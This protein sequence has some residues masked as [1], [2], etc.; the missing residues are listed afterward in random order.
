MAQCG[1]VGG[2][3]GELHETLTACARYYREE[4][5]EAIDVWPLVVQM[6]RALVDDDCH[7]QTRRRRSSGVA[8]ADRSEP[9]GG[10]RVEWRK[11]WGV[12]TET[13]IA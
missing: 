3:P 2:V 9:A 1:L 6:L 12:G 13:P 10:I 8:T 11:R 5:G 7:F 4:H